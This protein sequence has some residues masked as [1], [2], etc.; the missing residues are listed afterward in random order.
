MSSNIFPIIEIDSFPEEGTS[1]LSVLEIPRL[2][3][4]SDDNSGHFVVVEQDHLNG[5]LILKQGILTKE[6][7]QTIMTRVNE[8]GFYSWDEYYEEA[9][10]DGGVASITVNDQG[11]IKTVKHLKYTGKKSHNEVPESFTTLYKWVFDFVETKKYRT[12]CF[13]AKQ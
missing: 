5:V 13:L 7:I 6:D 9:I 12:Q 10:F 4:Y 1:D 3:I 11:K 2:R 8:S